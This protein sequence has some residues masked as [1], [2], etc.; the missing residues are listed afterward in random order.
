MKIKFF[1]ATRTVTG[2]CFLLETK[3]VKALIDCGLFQG[4]GKW[5]EKNFQHLPF[6]ASEIDFL[7]LTHAHID[8][9][10]RIPQLYK[11]GFRG[12]IYCTEPT[13]D[14]VRLMLFDSF[15]ILGRRAEKMGK[16]VPYSRADITKCLTLFEPIEYNKEIHPFDNF[17]FHFKDAGHILGSAIIE[18]KI[19]EGKETKRIVFS[20]D[21]GNPPVPLL[22]TIEKVRQADFVVIE[23]TYGNRLHESKKERRDLLEDAI[24]DI[25]RKQGTLLIPSFVLE[26]TQEILFELNALIENHKVPKIKIFVDGGLAAEAT[27]MYKKYPQ[28]FNKKAAYLIKSGDDLFKFSGL[29]FTKTKQESMVINKTP[30]PKIIVVAAG[31]SQ[32]GRVLHHELRYLSDPKNTLLFMGHQVKGTFG[33]K[34][35]DGQKQVEIFGNKVLVRARI[36]KILGYSAHG[37]QKILLS[38]LKN[39]KKP[40]KKVFVVHGEKESAQALCLKIRDSLG[41]ETNIPQFLEEFEL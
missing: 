35:A 29:K 32:G 40:I 30:G 20:G 1:G 3:E 18:I 5:V 33:R 4:H 37:D 41:L 36:S 16:T 28:F 7:L 13:I 19:K 8:H 2:S 15:G 24:E 17:S 39:I 12:K 38:W 11:Q 27:E 23:S 31:M 26:R 34:I 6:K 21:L 14:L 9:S 22:R 10:G 25:I